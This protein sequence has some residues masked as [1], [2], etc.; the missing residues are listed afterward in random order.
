MRTS[1][2][3]RLPEKLSRI[4]FI[5]I[6]HCDALCHP[7]GRNWA[8]C[9]LGLFVK[10]GLADLNKRTANKTGEGCNSLLSGVETFQLPFSALE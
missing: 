1:S 5:Q 9:S 4:S 2:L 10:K 3:T 7:P 6:P 8:G